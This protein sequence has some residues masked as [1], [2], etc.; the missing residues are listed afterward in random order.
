MDIAI[1][2]CSLK[3]GKEAI[4]LVYSILNKTIINYLNGNYVGQ[5]RSK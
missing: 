4:K 5:Q 3:Y 1:L 2:D